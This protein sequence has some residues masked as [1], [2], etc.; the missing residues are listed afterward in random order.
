MKEMSSLSQSQHDPDTRHDIL[1]YYEGCTTPD[2]DI[3]R[4]LPHVVKKIFGYLNQDALTQAR[5]VSKK[6]RCYVDTKTPYWKTLTHQ[7]IPKSGT[8]EEDE[9]RFWM[10]ALDGRQDIV[11]LM[12]KYGEPQNF[13]HALKGALE[14]CLDTPGMVQDRQRVQ[15]E[16]VKQILS[17]IDKKEICKPVSFGQTPLHLCVQVEVCTRLAGS[18]DQNKLWLETFKMLMDK[19][20]VKNPFSDN[21]SGHTPLHA[22]AEGGLKDFVEVIMDAVEEKCPTTNGFSE[23]TP[24]HLAALRGHFEVCQLINQRIPE[25]KNMRDFTGRT[26]AD[27][28]RKSILFCRR[29]SQNAREEAL[30]SIVELLSH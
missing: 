13:G 26:P 19:S 5:A 14:R 25:N 9:D 3:R 11:K 20:E 1:D 30:T 27:L 12:I 6:W 8:H 22:A 17:Y 23:M 21:M 10:A 16:I 24:L 2:G 18:S 29:E 28:A 7:I 4:A 15:S